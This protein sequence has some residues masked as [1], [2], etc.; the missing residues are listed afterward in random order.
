MARLPLTGK[1]GFK[2]LKSGKFLTLF[3]FLPK[4]TA[5]GLIPVAL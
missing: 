2:D 3:C 4:L 5:Q 1:L